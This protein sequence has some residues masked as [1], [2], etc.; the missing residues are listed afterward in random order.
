MQRAVKR[1]REKADKG[2]FLKPNRNKAGRS[3]MGKRKSDKYCVPYPMASQEEVEGGPITNSMSQQIEFLRNVI[4]SARSGNDSAVSLP[5]V[6]F[7]CQQQR[8]RP[9]YDLIAI[10]Q[11][12]CHLGI[13][14]SRNQSQQNKLTD[15]RASITAGRTF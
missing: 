7:V 13:E 5:R 12:L 9:I 8:Q 6:R 11:C 2:R 14:A 10:G 15:E 1:E 4:E 3:G